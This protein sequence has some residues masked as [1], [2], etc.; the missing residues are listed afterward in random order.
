MIRF[1]PSG[2][3]RRFGLEAFAVAGT[4]FVSPRSFANIALCAAA[5]LL[6]PAALIFRL[7][8]GVASDAAAA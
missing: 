1:K 4:G 5:I 7:L 8:A 3:I 6:R 2:L